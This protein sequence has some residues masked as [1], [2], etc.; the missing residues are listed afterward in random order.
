MSMSLVVMLSSIIVYL[1][2]VHIA[3]KRGWYITCLSRVRK[4]DLMLGMLSIS[5]YVVW[6]PLPMLFVLLMAPAYV[7]GVALVARL[8]TGVRYTERAWDYTLYTA[9]VC[10]LLVLIL[11]L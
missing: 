1:V 10:S 2:W 4:V 9:V 3:L 8:T 5:A 11:S 6:C 7:V